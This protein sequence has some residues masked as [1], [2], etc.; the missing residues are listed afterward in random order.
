MNEWMNVMIEWMIGMNKL[1]GISER[2][3]KYD[4]MVFSGV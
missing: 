2:H 1:L 4:G 3:V